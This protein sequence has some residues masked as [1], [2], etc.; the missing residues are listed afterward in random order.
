MV[1]ALAGWSEDDR[2]LVVARTPWPIKDNAA[3]L[4][5]VPVAGGV[6]SP[7]GTIALS[8]ARSFRLSPDAGS[9]SFAAGAPRKSMFVLD[10]IIKR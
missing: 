10:G 2:D 1:V 8:G 6:A 5:L 9:V 3:E 4:L 7:L